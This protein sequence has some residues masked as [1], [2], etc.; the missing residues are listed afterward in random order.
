MPSP[1]PSQRTVPT[2]LAGAPRPPHTAATPGPTTTPASALWLLRGDTARASRTPHLTRRTRR[3]RRTRLTGQTGQTRQTRQTRQRERRAIWADQLGAAS[4]ALLLAFAVLAIS[5]TSVAVY[6]L[7]PQGEL[8]GIVRDPSPT[9]EGLVFEDHWQGGDAAVD[10]VPPP[11]DVTV[12]Y[13]GY[14]SCPDMC[15]LTMGDLRRARQILGEELAARTQVAFVTLDPERDGPEELRT[16]L[17]LFFDERVLALTAPDGG[18]LDAAADR[19]GVRY[20][21]EA[22]SDATG[23][24]PDN[25]PDNDPDSDPGSDPDSYE[26]AHSAITYVIDDT[27]TVVR[28]LA[29]GT[30]PEEYARVIEHVL[31]GAS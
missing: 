23:S 6:A 19:L 24:D 3:T 14:L 25:D 27:G 22:P 4:G 29:F 12:A 7:W 26:V 11:G 1:T 5:A 28:E 30:T 15:P 18:A 21:L 2:Y 31:D 10:L 20:E 13:F 16:Y 9:V 8:P 17:S